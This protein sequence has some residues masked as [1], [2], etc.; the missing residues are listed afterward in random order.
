MPFPPPGNLPDTRMEPIFPALAGGFFTLSHQGSSIKQIPITNRPEPR[1]NSRKFRLPGNGQCS[2]EELQAKK[3]Q[4]NRRVRS[5]SERDGG[6]GWV[7]DTD[8]KICPWENRVS[9]E[10]TLFRYKERHLAKS[11]ASDTFRICLANYFISQGIKEVVDKL[12]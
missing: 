8:H 3:Q 6:W 10:L 12:F 11:R 9:W 2:Q 1:R 7:S 5:W 4:G